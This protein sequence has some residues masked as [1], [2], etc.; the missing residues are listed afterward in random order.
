MAEWWVDVDAGAVECTSSKTTLPPGCSEKGTGKKL[1]F[2][3][4][5]KCEKKGGL[6]TPKNTR[7]ILRRRLADAGSADLVFDSTDL[8][9]AEGKTAPRRLDDGGGDYGEPVDSADL[10]SRSSAPHAPVADQAVATRRLQV[11][12]GGLT[13]SP[14]SVQTALWAKQMES[15][16]GGV[17]QI[18]LR[19]AQL[20]IATNH[21]S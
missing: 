16:S 18:S 6:W 14:S 11:P 7:R 15:S 4:K 20:R 17:T 12:A 19:V 9:F 13:H 8:V 21:K 3:P 2:K 5:K 1:N 10:L